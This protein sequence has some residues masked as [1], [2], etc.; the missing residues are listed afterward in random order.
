VAAE[1]E[2]IRKARA[3][4]A[5]AEALNGRCSK[6]NISL[7]PQFLQELRRGDT[8]MICESCKRILYLNPPE[9]FEDLVPESV[10]QSRE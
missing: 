9:S 4:V 8:I 6:C 3:G 7:R 5:I 10:R 2:R 1:Y